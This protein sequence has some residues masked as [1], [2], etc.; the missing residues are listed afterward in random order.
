MVR[1]QLPPAPPICGRSSAVECFTH[2]EEVAGAAPAVRT[3]FQCPRSLIIERDASNVG[4]AGEIPAGGAN[5]FAVFDRRFTSTVRLGFR[6][7]ASIVIRKSSFLNFH[8]HVVYGEE[9][10]HL[11]QN[12]AALRVQVAPCPPFPIRAGA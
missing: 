1:L 2:T 8:G 12:Q 7:R 4:D 10:T 5:R 6:A 11:T 3:S 9:Q